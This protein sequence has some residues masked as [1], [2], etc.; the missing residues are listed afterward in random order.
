MENKKEIKVLK[1]K[2]LLDFNPEAPLMLLVDGMA[3]ELVLYGWGNEGDGVSDKS[4]CVDVLV[5]KAG[6]EEL[7]SVENE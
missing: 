7:Y 2:D 5:C 6:D 1:V 3:H 4:T